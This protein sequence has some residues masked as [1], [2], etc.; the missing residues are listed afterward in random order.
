MKYGCL[1]DEI[2]GGIPV[3]DCFYI[4]YLFHV[5]QFHLDVTR[6]VEVWSIDGLL[7]MVPE[8]I[9]GTCASSVTASRFVTDGR[10]T[11]YTHLPSVL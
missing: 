3:T 6:L 2:N 5:S 11:W 10:S 4:C 7:D 9:S 8:S 1:L